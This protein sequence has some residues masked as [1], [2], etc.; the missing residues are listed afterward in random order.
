MS[1]CFCWLLALSCTSSAQSIIPN[2]DFEDINNEPPIEYYQGPGGFT[3]RVRNWTSPTEGTSDILWY[4]HFWPEPI[5]SPAT[6]VFAVGLGIFGRIKNAEYAQTKLTTA[7]TPK[8]VYKVSFNISGTPTGRLIENLGIS[9]SCNPWRSRN[10]L[11]QDRRVQVAL[12]RPLMKRWQTVSGYFLADSAYTCLTVGYF[13][14]KANY[15]IYYAIDNVRI[16]TSEHNL[17]LHTPGDIVNLGNVN[18]ETGSAVLG[19]STEQ[20]LSG[21][22]TWL[23]ENPFRIAEVQGHTDN[24]GTAAD[25]LVLSQKRATA[26]QNWLIE[27]GIQPWQVQAV[28]YGASQPIA[29]NNSAAGKAANRRVCAKFLKILS[30]EEVYGSFLHAA[31][32][33][34]LSAAFEAIAQLSRIGDLPFKML[35]D[36]SLKALH[37]DPRWQKQVLEPIRKQFMAEKKVKDPG[38][39]FALELI[40]EEDQMMMMGDSLYWEDLKPAGFVQKAFYDSLAIQQVNAVHRKKLLSILKPYAGKLPAPNMVGEEAITGVF[41]V[42]QHSNDLAYQKKWVQEFKNLLPHGRQYAELYA[43]LSDRICVLENKPQLYGTQWLN[44]HLYKCVSEE[45]LKKNRAAIHLSD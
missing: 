4:P 42:V 24:V 39:A 13:N 2:G 3:N 36:P 19:P 28:G 22:L 29:A 10:S 21:L 20:L 30:I 26:V 44:D 32:A 34:D 23:K 37:S 38:T 9:F 27:K 35:I 14:P 8:T 33:T 1:A 11:I 17:D 7:L 18:F 15:E 25:N 31:S 40:K 6:G 45:E 5:D 16:E 12:D 43:M 41:L